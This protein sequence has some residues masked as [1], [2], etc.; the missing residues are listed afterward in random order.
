MEI[1]P[2]KDSHGQVV[3][4]RINNAE[5][6]QLISKLC[7]W[8]A[9]WIKTVDK[10]EFI[11]EGNDVMKNYLEYLWKKETNSG[12]QDGRRWNYETNESNKDFRK[13]DERINQYL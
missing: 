7:P 12:K 11:K 9:S 2:V 1:Y 4:V 13:K 5:L 6:I 3:Q 8:N 10:L